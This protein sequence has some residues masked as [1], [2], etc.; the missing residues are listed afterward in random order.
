M[1]QVYKL[2]L[3]GESNYQ[4]FIRRCSVGERVYLVEEMNNP[5]DAGALAV[6][7]DGGATLGY[8]PRD[9]WLR[10]VA[11]E[12]KQTRLTVKSIAD[13]GSGHLGVV[14]N[15]EVGVGSDPRVREYSPPEANAPKRAADRAPNKPVLAPIVGSLLKSLFRTRR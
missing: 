11:E 4:S 12:G 9:S 3:V 14:L 8:V 2:G 10:R 13:G 5:Y 6:T 7:R 15:V 1:E